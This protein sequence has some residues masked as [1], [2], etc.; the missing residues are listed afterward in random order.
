MKA[1]TISY[2]DFFPKCLAQCLVHSKCSINTYCLYK[3]MNELVWVPVAGKSSSYPAWPQRLRIQLCASSI[4]HKT[5]LF[6]IILV[7]RDSSFRAEVSGLVFPGYPRVSR[8]QDDITINTYILLNT[9]SLY[10]QTWR[11]SVINCVLYLEAYKIVRK[12][13]F[14]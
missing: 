3:W 7:E 12:V 11:L 4:C 5:T 1:R 10:L 14:T 6:D 2:A 13:Y 8:L 9:G